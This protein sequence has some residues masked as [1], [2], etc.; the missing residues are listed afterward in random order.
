[1]KC[2]LPA[3]WGKVAGSPPARGAWIEI[4]SVASVTSA[5]AASPPARGAWIE[6][7]YYVR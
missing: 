6:I 5:I 3:A 7:M 1:M 4:S 2:L